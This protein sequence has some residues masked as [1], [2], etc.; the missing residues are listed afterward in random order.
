MTIVP[1]SG[2]SRLDMYR[3]GNN[4]LGAVARDRRAQAPDIDAANRSL[5]VHG[6]AVDKLFTPTLRVTSG[7]H[8]H[9][10]TA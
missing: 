10:A 9:L 7:R 6:E 3:L 8:A 1:A 4:V 2:L 5:A